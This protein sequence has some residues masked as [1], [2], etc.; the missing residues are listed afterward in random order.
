MKQADIRRV[1]IVDDALEPPQMRIED[2]GPLTDMLSKAEL[3]PRLDARG[4][5]QE[6][7]DQALEALAATDLDSEDVDKVWKALFRAFVENEV[8]QFDPGGRFAETKGDNVRALRPFVRLLKKCEPAIDL[9][10]VGTEVDV[11]DFKDLKPQLVFLDYILDGRVSV[12]DPSADLANRKAG[13]DASRKVLNKI[14]AELPTDGPSVVL[15]SSDADVVDEADDYRHKAKGYL[16]SSRFQFVPK[17]ALSIDGSKIVIESNAAGTLLDLTQCQAFGVELNDALNAWRDGAEKALK[18]IFAEIMDLELRDFAYLVRFRLTEEGQ[19]LSEY[20]EWFF[21]ELLLDGVSQTVDWKHKSFGALNLHSEGPGRHIEGMFDGATG[22]I[23]EMFSRVRV[24]RR[25]IE[26]ARDRRMGDLYMPEASDKEIRAVLTPD[27][28]LLTRSSGP[29][30]SRMLTVSGK[31]KDID[32]PN[33]SAADFFEHGG[34]K[35]S[36]DWNTKDLQTLPFGEDKNHPAGMNYV[37]TF[38]PLY[39]Y[40]LQRRVLDDF[41]RVGLATAPA[42]HFTASCTAYSRAAGKFAMLPIK[43]TAAVRC[44][45]MPSRGGS[46]GAKIMFHRGFVEN[47]VDTLQAIELPKITQESSDFD[48]D[49]H[50]FLKSVRTANWEADMVRKL[51]VSGIEDGEPY[52]GVIVLIRDEPKPKDDRAM[53][54]IIVQPVAAEVAPGDR[55]TTE[56]PAEG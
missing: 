43:K 22:K 48:K 24:D 23:A 14:V 53:C 11:I 27:C 2:A 35:Y 16:F 8:Q 12:S 26:N 49:R 39:A 18:T 21:G 6:L 36:I 50:R 5:G 51:L 52:K 3:A 37:G 19:P 34:N 32:A 56:A 38:R 54:Q 1:V 7:R 17:N 47:L 31:L 40:E 10:L 46:S 45:V 4:I 30:A 55:E 42:V 28:D 25:P 20:L 41:G 29:R 9:T 13:V 33:V 15:M 44:S